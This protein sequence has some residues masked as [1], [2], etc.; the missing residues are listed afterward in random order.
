MRRSEKRS[1][2]LRWKTAKTA[3]GRW[4]RSCTTT[5]NRKI[6]N[7]R[8][9]IRNSKLRGKSKQQ[10]FHP[11]IRLTAYQVR[12]AKGEKG[13]WPTAGFGGRSIGHRRRSH[14][15]TSRGTEIWRDERNQKLVNEQ[16]SHRER[17]GSATYAEIN[18]D[19]SRRKSQW[20][21]P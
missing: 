3:Q 16:R 1:F 13:A 2:E 21:D 5:S 6:T 17:E 4:T 19:N 9:V 8:A 7:A 14:A 10:F 18:R 15:T 11:N 12:P 20:V